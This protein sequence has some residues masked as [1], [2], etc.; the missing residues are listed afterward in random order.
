MTVADYPSLFNLRRL[1][2]NNITT[3]YP[4][5]SA[6][7]EDQ[8]LLTDKW[9]KELRNASINLGIKSVSCD[10]RG[11]LAGTLLSHIEQAGECDVDQGT[12]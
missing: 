12:R 8:H 10:L 6:P 3:L 11:D 4:E 5:G 9:I 2:C 7:T 1:Q